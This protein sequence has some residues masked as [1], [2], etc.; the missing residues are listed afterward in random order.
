MK[1]TSN[2]RVNRR[3]QYRF[4]QE[5]SI[6][7]TEANLHTLC[8]LSIATVGA[9]LALGLVSALFANAAPL[10]MAYIAVLLAQSG[11]C[12]VVNLGADRLAH[13]PG[14]VHALVAVYVLSVLLFLMYIGVCI[15]PNNSGVFF[16]LAVLAL[17]LP[18]FLPWPEASA[19][20]FVAALLF[21]TL[22]GAYKTPLVFGYDACTSLMAWLIGA[23]LCWKF[24]HLRICAF[25]QQSQLRRLSATD[26][27][28]GLYKCEELETCVE[29]RL[30][31]A[32]QGDAFV[33]VI[34]RLEGI[35]RVNKIYGREVG[36]EIF[37][38]VGKCIISALRIGEAYLPSIQQPYELAGRTDWDEI[39]LLLADANT[40]A[41]AERRTQEL[42]RQLEK[43]TVTDGRRVLRCDAGLALY[44]ADGMRYEALY[45]HA[46][47]E[48]SHHVL[49]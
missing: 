8:S 44:P 1:H 29:N 4:F 28:T 32:A 42:Q 5:M 46:D 15:R 11:L 13:K 41:D 43:I 45:R 21:C 49:L 20:A 39:G 23:V 31:S 6:P 30:N 22:S 40:Y 33:L 37:D 9:L 38:T 36:D 34:L 48:L 17:Q 14:A 7:I 18:F 26:G 3:S 12:L 35:R 16:V 47:E 24:H 2:A 25:Q 27:Q 10:N 19:V